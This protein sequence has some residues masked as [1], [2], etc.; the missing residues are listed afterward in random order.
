MQ[1]ALPPLMLQ[2]GDEK[3]GFVVHKVTP[4]KNL[5]SVAYELEHRKTG[6]RLLHV[7]NS[8]A[9]NLFCIAFRT[10]PSD[11][12]GLPHILEHSVLAGSKKFPVK[13][14]FVEMVKASM[15]T[16]INAM[17]YSDKTIYP[18]ASNVRKDFYNLATV[19]CDAVFHPRLTEETFKQE[20]HHLELEKK[21]GKPADP[22]KANLIVKGI[23]YNEMK[24][25]YSDADAYV[26]NLMQKHTFPA[27]TYGRD[28]G[29]DP[30]KIPD[31]TYKDFKRF[32]KDL[33][34]PSNSFIFLYG[35]IPT[36]DHLK[37]LK[38]ELDLFSK[39]T[40]DTSIPRQKRFKAEKR[41]KSPYPVGAKEPTRSKTYLVMNWLVGDGT[42][43]LDVLTL[44]VLDY[45]LL[46]NAA[47]PLRKALIDSK[48]GEDLT[49]C[50]FSAGTLECTYSIGL[51]GSEASRAEKFRK[52]VLGTLAKLAEEGLPREVVDTAFQQIAYK[53]FE[54]QSMFPLWQMDRSYA[55]WIY[56]ADPLAFLRADELMNEIRLRYEQDPAYFS[57]ILKE[58]FLENPHRVFLVAYPDRKM[59]ARKDAKF[60]RRMRALKARLKSRDLARIA[61]EAEKLEALQGKPNSPRALATLPRLK[62][63]EL[64]RKPRHIPTSVEPLSNGVEVLRNDVF[65][66]GVSYLHLDVDLAGLPDELIPCL[67]LYSDAVAKMGAAGRDWVAISRQAASHTGGVR[68]FAYV[69]AHIA[70]PTRSV[71]HGRF[72]LKFLD[73]KADEALAI[74]RDI[75]LEMDPRDAARLKDVL[76]QTKAAHRSMIVSSALDLAARHAARHLTRETWVAEQLGGLPQTQLVERLCEDFEAQHPAL[77][78]SLTRIRDFMRSRS[79]ITASFTGSDAVYRK[80]R[81]SLEAWTGQMRAESV[82]AGCPTFPVSAP[83][84]AGL[85]APMEVAYCTQVLPAPHVSHPDSPTLVVASR[86]L[87]LGYMWEEVRIKGGAY[88]GGSAYNGVDRTWQFYS[89]RDPWI[90]R[91]YNTFRGLIEHVKKAKWSQAD[92]DRAIIGTAK[93]GERPVRPSEAT[94]T[95]LWRHANGDTRELRELRHAA[96]LA[97]TPAKVKAAVLK[98]LEEN[99]EKGGV[100][101]VSS[102]EKIEQANK[103][104]PDAPFAIEE[105]MKS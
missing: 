29:G 26:D 43:P 45:A 39:R 61:K 59:Q 75:F 76:L 44:S 87:S 46:G 30:E 2:P 5:R 9:E 1:N 63:S 16:F 72:T 32:Y 93:H 10:P 37:F 81:G 19:Y 89:Y 71:Q 42:N 103:E 3:L 11:D 20:G 70:D 95:A 22:A 14:P 21:N 69:N 47:A 55:T 77:M 12:T 24:G 85:A 52:L 8:D 79:R 73:G 38:K 50:G 33:Y 74:F 65:A 82:P 66:N 18:V 28:S 51:K 56:G 78:E 88:G 17:T 25:A 86:L 41:I 105:I 54:I 6:A 7:H 101:V 31:L 94:S 80:V 15:A 40:I 104:T 67:S 36:L 34:H 97:V 4:L 60:A 83:G 84:R 91:T 100:C 48:L 96:Y 53:Y 62:A 27:T 68:F 64:P 58:R 49:E 23:V 57:K 98:V 90:T 99:F 102:R 35:D 13:D 92:I